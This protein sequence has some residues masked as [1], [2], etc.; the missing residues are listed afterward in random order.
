MNNKT[1]KDFVNEDLNVFFN[2]DEFA[3]EHELEG[4]LLT[5]IVVDIKSDNTSTTGIQR[6]QLYASQEVFKQYKTIYVKDS[7]FYIP[8]IDSVLDLDG[9]KYFVEEAGMEKGVIR[10]L[11]SAHE[12]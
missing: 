12:S 8:K 7:D 6:D 1:F 9:E 4:K 5:M 11:L 10:I 3:E 2:L